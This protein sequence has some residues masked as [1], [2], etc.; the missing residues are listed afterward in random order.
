MALQEIPFETL[1]GSTSDCSVRV[2]FT[3]ERSEGSPFSPL[4]CR[5]L[6]QQKGSSINRQVMRINTDFPYAPVTASPAHL[7]H[8]DSTGAFPPNNLGYFTLYSKVIWGKLF[9]LNTKVVWGIFCFLLNTKV[10]W[11]NFLFFF[12]KY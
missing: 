1:W 9:L 3:L 10:L 4:S 11:G 8:K 5:V 12:T 7:N 6:T 2:H